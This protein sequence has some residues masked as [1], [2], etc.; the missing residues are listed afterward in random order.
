M[1][2]AACA[3][4]DAAPALRA[5]LVL[6]AHHPP[7]DHVQRLQACLAHLTHGLAYGVV[8]ND[9]RPGEAV[10]ALLPGAA[11]T[12][13]QRANPGYGRA[14][15]Q[16]WQRWC[17]AHGEPPLGAVLITDLSWESGCFEQLAAWLEQHPD[18]TAAMPEL[19]FPDGRR[20]FLCKR[21][22]TLLALISRRFI[23]R[24]LKPRRL[25]RYDHWY[26]MRDQPY[27]RVFASPYLSGC[28][29]WMRGWEVQAIAF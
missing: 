14:F 5:L 23:P 21:N 13:V 4:T 24:H 19:R 16:L 8:V 1:P 7:A 12:V 29:L 28:C 26:T 3:D 25:R 9:H 10:D 6:I 11:M 22:P 18:V 15:N 27:S 17:Q 2:S 20:Q